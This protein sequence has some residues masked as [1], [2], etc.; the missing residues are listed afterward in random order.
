MVGDTATRNTIGFQRI[1]SGM[2]VSIFRQ[3]GNGSTVNPGLPIVVT[4]LSKAEVRLNGEILLVKILRP[5]VYTVDQIGPEALLPG[6]KVKISDQL[7]RSETF[8]KLILADEK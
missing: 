2:G 4:H 6:A 3:G 5:G 8:T 1:V 7:S